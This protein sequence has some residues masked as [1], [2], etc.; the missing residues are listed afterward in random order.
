MEGFVSYEIL[1][2]DALFRGGIVFSYLVGFSFLPNISGIV[3]LVKETQAHLLTFLRFQVIKMVIL[4]RE[5]F[6]LHL[7]TFIGFQVF[8]K[9]DGNEKHTLI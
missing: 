2:L 4:V 8:L 6:Q 9:D 7:L 1:R 3:I 5:A